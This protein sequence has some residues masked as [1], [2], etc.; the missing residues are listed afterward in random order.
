MGMGRQVERHGVTWLVGF[1]FVAFCGGFLAETVRQDQEMAARRRDDAAVG[2]QRFEFAVPI[3]IDSREL[4]RVAQDAIVSQPEIQT[5]SR[6]VVEVFRGGEY[7]L[8]GASQRDT[9]IFT[10][11]ARRRDSWSIQEDLS[12]QVR[13]AFGTA[14]NRVRDPARWPRPVYETLDGPLLPPAP[15]AAAGRMVGLPPADEAPF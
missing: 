7:G 11:P 8:G 1:V 6:S 13:R 12:M 9:L 5:T 14:L 4:Q 2:P 3:G 15:G 10:V